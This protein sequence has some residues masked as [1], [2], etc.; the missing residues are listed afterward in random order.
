MQLFAL[1]RQLALYLAKSFDRLNDFFIGQITE[2]GEH[3]V[4]HNLVDQ[5]P[6]SFG[7]NG[8]HSLDV[9]KVG[10]QFQDHPARQDLGKGFEK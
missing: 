5:S 8:R 4:V 3:P 10:F 7:R 1:S 2:L 6:P 9:S